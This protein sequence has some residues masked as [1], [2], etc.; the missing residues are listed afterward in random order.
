MLIAAFEPGQAMAIANFSLA[1]FCLFTVGL[2]LLLITRGDKTKSNRDF[3]AAT[4]NPWSQMGK[5][6]DLTPVVISGINSTIEVQ[7]KLEVISENN[8]E[9]ISESEGVTSIETICSE[10][11]EKSSDQILVSNDEVLAA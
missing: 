7:P 5:E 10:E 1:I 11:L 8:A 2:P 9:D 6:I 3:I 4:V